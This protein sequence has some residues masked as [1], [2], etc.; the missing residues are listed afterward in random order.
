MNVKTK[1]TERWRIFSTK[2]KNRTVI[3][4]NEKKNKKYVVCLLNVEAF[5][6]H[7]YLKQRESS[8]LRPSA[9]TAGKKWV[10]SELICNSCNTE[11]HLEAE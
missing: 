2:L 6:G 1:L 7:F 10:G 11:Y 5:N 3:Q 8:I 4:T 9:V